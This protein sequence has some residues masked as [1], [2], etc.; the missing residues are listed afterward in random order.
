MAHEEVGLAISAL[1]LR[2]VDLYEMENRERQ[3][4]GQQPF[5]CV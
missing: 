2:L 4:T 5:C 1:L 3:I